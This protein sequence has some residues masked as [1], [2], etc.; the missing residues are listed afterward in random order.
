M[1][2]CIYIVP[3][4]VLFCCDHKGFEETNNVLR[5]TWMKTMFSI[6]AP[7]QHASEEQRERTGMW[8][9]VKDAMTCCQPK[10]RFLV[11]AKNVD[12][13]EE[14][15]YGKTLSGNLRRNQYETCC[16]V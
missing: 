16:V 12:K 3:F 5:D 11:I 1:A 13:N 10:R 15:M 8:C 14:N 4:L 7:V 2:E 9:R 6:T